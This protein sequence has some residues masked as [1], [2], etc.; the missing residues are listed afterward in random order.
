MILMAGLANA[1]PKLRLIASVAPALVHPGVFAKM[2]ATLD[3]V[4]GGRIG[5]NIV[6]AANKLEYSQMGLFPEN[7]EDFRYEYTEEWLTLVK[8]L[9]SEPS[10]THQGKYFTLEDCESFPHPS[11]NPLPIVCATSS[12]RG[13]EFIAEHCTDGFFGGNTLESKVGRSRRIKDV[14]AARGRA[15]RTHTLIML[16]QGEDDDDA[17]KMLQHYL[18]GAD[19]E[20]IASIYKKRAGAKPEESIGLLR[21]RFERNDTRVFYG[22]L[23]LAAG[24][25][26]IAD[27]IEQLVVDGGLDGVMFTFPDFPIGL[28][29]FGEG[30][31]PLLRRRGLVSRAT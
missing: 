20:T 28:R 21:E 8:R 9:W 10:V 12:E 13:F 15:V 23:P 25:E 19:E 22:G 5:I 2:A 11:Q 30:V 1:A 27:T 4:S 29:R 16:I 14:A 24:P 26:R 6:S 7:F 17:Q 31:M 3:D 18:D